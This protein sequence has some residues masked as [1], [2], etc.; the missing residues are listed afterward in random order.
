MIFCALHHF[1]KSYYKKQKDRSLEHQQRIFKLQELENKRTLIKIKNKRLREDVK[2]KNR[3]LADSTIAVINK[4]NIL[5]VIKSKLSGERN[6]PMVRKVIQIIEKE[7]DDKVHWN[8]FQQ[9]FNEIDKQF[10]SKLKKKHP[11]LTPLD[12]RLCIYL[13]LN[14]TSKEIA[15]LFNISYKSVEVKRYRLRRKMDLPP[16][17]N[18][19]H[20]ILEV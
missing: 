8:T 13:R 3:A 11:N 18:L 6:T 10:L 7:T 4:N 1:Y 9:A 17:K 14:M 5:N 20:Y 15:P 12:L 19:I 16:Q 2:S